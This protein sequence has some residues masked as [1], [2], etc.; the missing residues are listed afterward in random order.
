V[1]DFND[2]RIFQRLKSS[3]SLGKAIGSIQATIR[4][5]YLQQAKYRVIRFFA[6]KFGIQR[7]PGF[8]P[9]LPAQH[10]QLLRGVYIFV[11]V[12]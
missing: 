10:T 9:D 12:S 4:R 8:F 6:Q 5:R 3:S 7:Q 1:K 2:S 11:W